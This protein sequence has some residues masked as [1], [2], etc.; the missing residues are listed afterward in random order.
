MKTLIL[1]STLPLLAALAAAQDTPPP[2]AKDTPSETIRKAEPAAWLGIA[3]SEK[4]GKVLVGQVIPKSPAAKAGLREGDQILRI[5]DRAI[6]GDMMRLS[7]FVS[8]H[9]PGDAVELRILRGDKEETLKVE[10]AARPELNDDFRGEFRRKEPEADQK[11]KEAD[12]GPE[13]RKEKIQDEVEKFENKIRKDREM[14]KERIEKLRSHEEKFEK[15]PRFKIDPPLKGAHPELHLE[16]APKE[17]EGTPGESLLWRA[18]LAPVREEA[19]WKRVEESVGRAL[20]ES[21]VGPDVIEKAMAAV[22]EAR[23]NGPEQ[24]ARRAKLQ[25]EAARIEK[26]MQALKEKAGKIREELDKPSE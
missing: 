1:A 22:K 20:K 16:Y 18:K 3:M 17:F 14:L 2:P 21:G 6:E 7:G 26:E 15:M 12:E 10:L 4:D 25:A 9:K 5:G 23:K 24:Q 13:K 11:S 19:I 8:E